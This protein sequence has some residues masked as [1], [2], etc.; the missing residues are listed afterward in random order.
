MAVQGTEISLFATDANIY[1]RSGSLNWRRISG[2]PPGLMAMLRSGRQ[3]IF[4]YT[5]DHLYQRDHGVWRTMAAPRLTS[6]DFQRG[7]FEDREGGVWAGMLGGVWRIHEGRIETLSLAP[8]LRRDDLVISFHQSRDGTMWCGTRWGALVRLE[9]PKF[10]VVDIKDGLASSAMAAVQQDDEGRMWLGSRNRGPYVWK[11]G[12]WSKVPGL[13]EAMLHAMRAVGSGGRM[14]IANNSGLW[15][16]DGEQSR[17]L[18]ARPPLWEPA[19][20]QAISTVQNGVLYYGDSQNVHRLR[21]KGASV[22]VERDLTRMPLVRSLVQ[23]GDVL[24][25]M[26]W[27]TGLLEWRNGRVIHHGLGADK[28]EGRGMTLFELDSRWLLVGTGSGTLLFDRQSRR[29]APVADLCPGEPIFGFQSDLEGN[30]WMLGR[31]GLLVASQA[32]I[33][34]YA[35]GRAPRPTP[36]RFTAMQGLSSGN[37]GLGTSSLSTLSSNGL[38]WLA[39]MSGA[40]HFQ[41]SQVMAS[42]GQVRV[43]VNRLEVDGVPTA[44]DQTWELPA[45]TKRLGI[46]FTTVGRVAGMNP[47]FRYHLRGVDSEPAETQGQEA[48]FNNLGP[49]KYRFEVQAQLSD[50]GWR[51]E[52]AVLE[53]SIAPLWYQRPGVTAISVVLLTGSA[54]LLWRW[55]LT[56]LVRQTA[57]LENR[58]R[59]RTEE[60]RAALASKSQFLASMSHE[61][62]TPMNG[63]LGMVQLLE[64]EVRDPEHRQKLGI[65]RASGDTLLHIVNDILD[66]SKIESGAMELERVPFSVRNVVSECAGLFQAQITERGLTLAT[67]VEASVPE[68][69]EGDPS[70]VRQ[71]LVNLMSNAIKFTEHGHVTLQVRAEELGPASLCFEIEDTGIG[72]PA[73]KID[74]IFEPFT[75]AEASTTRRY[76]GTG[77]GLTICSR[78]VTAMG[79]SLSVESDVHIGSR[80]SVRL[81]LAAAAPP[82][83]NTP[84]FA[85]NEAVALLRVLV[86][87]DNHINRMVVRA[88]L[89]RCDCEVTEACDGREAIR[90]G[91]TQSFDLIL[92][93]L[94]MPGLDGFETCRRIRSECGPNQET[95][96]W[97]LSASAFDEDKAACLAAGMQGHLAKPIDWDELRQVLATQRAA[98]PAEAQQPVLGD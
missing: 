9:N 3:G 19:R 79:G 89:E 38:V 30:I 82:S 70:R 26:S 81:P 94:H 23:D 14:L 83:V 36:F 62:R 15:I 59:E 76:G 41:P 96:I 49:G 80:F 7:L 45:G 68:W 50:Q 92:M 46:H 25:G 60:L 84:P 54:F 97:A 63:V 21:I 75:Q 13:G 43:A 22:E 40:M 91:S 86:V 87:E 17:L 74:K 55:R 88:M 67:T 20:Y 8:Y 4:G 28:G 98:A 10:P 31:R 72:I 1:E 29:Y 69:V 95:V 56:R 32:R 5:M 73:D 64:D 33:I 85:P 12:R 39:S 66:L 34:D 2:S 61:I 35:E 44:V 65:L 53:F 52:P 58:V 78:L 6:L 51:E 42:R 27:E 37:F 57:E 47:T 24:W 48:I 18:L 11:A 93:D 16:S 90:T 71:I 77:L